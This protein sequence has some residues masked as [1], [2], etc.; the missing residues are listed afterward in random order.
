MAATQSSARLNAV[1]IR[2]FRS[3]LQYVEEC[4]AWADMAEGD[5]EQAVTSMRLEQQA[6]VGRM[7]EV[8]A[9]RGWPIDFGNF[10]TEYT[11]LHYVALDFLLGELVADESQLIVEAERVRTASADDPEVFDLLAKLVA[12]EQQHMAR[13]SALAAAHATAASSS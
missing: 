3:L 4:S 1:L 2:T 7:V 9:S 10:P 6:L 12:A 11:D 5:V 8:L 13:F